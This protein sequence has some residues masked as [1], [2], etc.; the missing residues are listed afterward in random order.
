[1]RVEETDGDEAGITAEELAFLGED[2]I[3]LMTNQ[4]INP[5]KIGKRNTVV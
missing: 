1:M 2:S 4:P 3:R 5:I